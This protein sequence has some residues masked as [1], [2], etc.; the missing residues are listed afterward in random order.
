MSQWPSILQSTRNKQDLHDKVD[1]YENS[2]E[3]I[4]D[5]EEADRFGRSQCTPALKCGQTD[6]EGNGKHDGCAG[7]QQPDGESGAVFVELEANKAVDH[8]TDACCGCETVLDGD[9][10]GIWT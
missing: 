4:E 7:S 1:E 6:E 2:T 5:N 9:K 8:Q 10:V 3:D